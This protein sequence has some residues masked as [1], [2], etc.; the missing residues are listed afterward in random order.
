MTQKQWQAVMG[1]NLSYFYSCGDMCPVEQ[2]S[3]GDVQEFIGRLNRREGMTTYRLPTEAEWE[4]AAWAGTQ[5]AHSFGDEE[6]QLCL[7][8]NHADR[9]TNYV[10]T[11]SNITCADGVGV[12][13]APVGSYLPNGW[14]LYDMHGNVLELVADWYS[15]YPSGPVTDPRGP[16]TGTDRIARGGGWLQDSRYS[17]SAS[18]IHG[19]PSARSNSLGFRLARTLAP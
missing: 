13:T 15:D 8:A 19:P 1:S 3:W 12:S 6:S 9:S 11:W 14:G 7:Y 18:R 4:Y 17:R 10:N 5:T 16:S 2:V